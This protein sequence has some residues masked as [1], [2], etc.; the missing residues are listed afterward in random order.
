MMFIA[1]PDA[2]PALVKDAASAI[3]QTPST[4]PIYGVCAFA[5]NTAVMGN[6]MS[7][8][9]F[10][11]D[12]L[13]KE[14]I[15]RL[16]IND[17]SQ[18]EWDWLGRWY[19]QVTVNVL[20]GPQHGKIDSN[21][22]LAYYAE[23]G[24][25]GKDRMEVLVSSKDMSGRTISMK[26]IYFI[27]VVSNQES[28]NVAESYSQS[29]L[30]YCHAKSESWRRAHAPTSSSPQ[31]EVTPYSQAFDLPGINMSFSDLAGSAV[32]LEHKKVDGGS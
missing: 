25:E 27:N 24:Y 5:N 23:Q 19:E 10:L 6:E 15:E 29:L 22:S 11:L 12:L 30:K 13:P 7:P 16:K 18:N 8:S 14:F 1:P 4:T 20:S 3:K 26:V 9:R 32:G 2:A 21:A 31:G 17:L 28:K